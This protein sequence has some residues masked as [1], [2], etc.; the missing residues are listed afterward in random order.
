MKITFRKIRKSDYDDLE[1]II[2]Q[3]FFKDYPIS[4]RIKKLVARIMLQV[5]IVSSDYSLVAVDERYPVG[6]ILGSNK[7]AKHKGGNYQNYVSA[8]SAILKVLL[9]SG[10]ERKFIK[11]A[12]RVGDTYNSFMKKHKH[13]YNSSVELFALHEDYRGLG[14][15]K[16]LMHSY[17]GHLNK[18]DIKGLYLFTDD[19][20]TYQFY[21]R[22]GFKRSEEKLITSDFKDLN[23]YLYEFEDISKLKDYQ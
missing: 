3:A 16:Q 7:I 18:Y 21:E 5:C 22:N 8:L 14:I 10:K 11:E 19:R 20:C 23:I 12:I 1:V 17:L 13:E 2:K 9:V 15:G 4:N 6:L